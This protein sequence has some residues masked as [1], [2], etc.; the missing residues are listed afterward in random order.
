MTSPD[1]H[2]ALTVGEPAGIGP[3]ITVA[4]ANESPGCQITALA[5]PDLL[6][7]RARELG[8]PLR[9]TVDGQGEIHFGNLEVDSTHRLAVP[10]RAGKLDRAN[11]AYVHDTIRAAAEGCLDG[12]Y[13][14]MVTAPVHKGIIN[15]A[16]IPFSGHTELIAEVCGVDKPVMMLANDKL[17]VALVTTHLPLRAVPDAISC[18]VIREVVEVV[19]AD[20]RDKFGLDRPAILV[21][22]LN[23]HAGENGHLGREELDVIV[24]CLERLKN[25]GLRLTGPVPADTAFA[26]HMLA[27]A[28]VVIAMYH[29][30]GLPVIKAQGF[31]EVV[32]IT[33]GLPVVRTSVDHGT[34]L[35]LAGTGKASA[36][37]LLAAIRQ[38]QR[39]IRQ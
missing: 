36:S 3:D 27:Q 29:D 24:P 34:A 35:D 39:M 7:Q 13:A 28:D 8:S 2:L 37:S 20:L 30:Q 21:C 22:G 31:G 23:P 1:L 14:G 10:A 26:P 32:N 12:R 15:E 6:D 18:E 11:G 25:R 17:R 5:D 9:C 38:A 19:E 33:L 16:G 4:I